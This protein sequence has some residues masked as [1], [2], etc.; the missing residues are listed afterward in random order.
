M[1]SF[2]L[3]ALMTVGFAEENPVLEKI[4][5]RCSSEWPGDFRMQKHC[6]ERQHEGINKLIAF[7]K[8]NG[9]VLDK[10]DFSDDAKRTPYE[11]MYIKCF[12]DW[13]DEDKGADYRML[14]YCIERQEEAYKAL[15]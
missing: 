5:V 8:R 6:I 9:V 12:M 7:T 3:A 4:K 14:S 10:I 13:F 11:E 15:K 1:I 2:V